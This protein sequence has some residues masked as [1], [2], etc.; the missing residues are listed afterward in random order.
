MNAKD[1]QEL[2]ALIE[3]NGVEEISN[4]LLSSFEDETIEINAKSLGNIAISRGDVILL[5]R[6]PNNGWEL[7]AHKK[8]LMES[9]S[10]LPLSI[11]DVRIP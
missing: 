3:K 11:S 1:A 9:A 10:I 6:S 5:S 2:D 8:G 7:T 4:Y